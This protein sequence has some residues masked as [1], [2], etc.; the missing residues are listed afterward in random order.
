MARKRTPTPRPAP[1]KSKPEV[2]VPPAVADSRWTALTWEDLENWAGSRSVSR[3]RSYQ[4]GGRVQDLAVT[5]DGTLLATVN[6]GERYATTVSLGPGHQEAALESECTCPVGWRCKHAVA[7]VA[8]YLDALADGRDLPLAEEDDPR[9]AR[10][11][12]AGES[13]PWDDE[14]DPETSDGDGWDEDGEEVEEDPSA[15]RRPGRLAA[16]TTAMTRGDE[17]LAAYI[18]GQSHDDLVE[19]VL[20]FVS[21]FPEL[22]EEFRERLALSR[23]DAGRLVSQT[24]QAIR[25]VTSEPAW[26][27]HWSGES[28][29]PDYGPIQ[30]RLERLLELGQADAV[31][32][33]GRELLRA[34]IDQVAQADDEGETGLQL[35]ESLKVV[36]RAVMRSSL[37]P[38]ER[39]RF[40]IES[41]LVDDY[42]IVSEATRPIFEAEHTAAAWSEVADA[43]AVR[44]NAWR[45]E[46][47]E[48]ER[49]WSR[50]YGRKR[51]TD[52]IADALERAG[53]A[54]EV[55][56]LFEAEARQNG[57]YVRLV[58]H[59]IEA[60]ELDAAERWAREGIG[61][62]GEKYAGIERDLLAHLARLARARGQLDVVAAHQAHEFFHGHHP[63]AQGFEDLMA[64]ARDAGMEAAVR[65]AALHFLETG[66]PPYREEVPP[67]APAPRPKVRRASAGERRGRT[68]EPAVTETAA[69]PKVQ[70]EKD[71]PLP[72][73]DELLSR[74]NRRKAW[75]ENPRPHL[76]VLIE[77][78]LRAQ[79]P[80]EALR[81]YDRL[82]ALERSDPYALGSASAL[83]DRVAG[84][85]AAAF[86]ERA[87]GI[88]LENLNKVLPQTG[89]SAYERAA[90]YLK[91]LRPIHAALGRADDWTKLVATLRE[92]YARRRLFLEILD[93]LDARSIVEERRAG[94]RPAR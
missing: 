11:A 91:L 84:A 64:A 53:R 23:G 51:L 77:L 44:L 28:H 14:G 18:G 93:R 7:V 17:A 1:P 75:P 79:D 9:W 67:P 22:R 88:Y 59:L 35:A 60:Q 4:K 65:R 57:D 40:A 48:D 34:G 55:R 80:E 56:P 5:D 61:A 29:L 89:T 66:T 42:G 52:R 90:S 54:V 31:V 81:W 38:S 37:T 70:V 39:L 2:S 73:P 69:P 8:E 46:G 87:I 49:A 45:P 74:L 62:V 6:G 68:A 13:R 21:R 41:E 58:E 25:Q 33:V 16:I 10:L 20:S 76:D 63:S 36:F 50:T 12:G 72:L 43:L 94:R 71:W 15:S 92:T 30:R 24:R 32:E 85:V 83:G 26:R 27:H 47:S 19:L 86:P 3:G 78:A 82:R